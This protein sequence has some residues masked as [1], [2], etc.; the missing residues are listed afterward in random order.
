VFVYLIAEHGGVTERSI[1]RQHAAQ[2]QSDEYSRSA[3][4]SSPAEEI[5]QAKQLLDSGAITREEFDRIK[6]Q[7]LAG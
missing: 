4:R 3:T 7:A 5:A 2:K 1:E 6:E